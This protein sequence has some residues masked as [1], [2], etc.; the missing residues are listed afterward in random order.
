M[1]PK[2]ASK[3]HNLL[4]TRLRAVA[5][6]QGSA[7]SASPPVEPAALAPVAGLLFFSGFCALIFQVSW[8]REFRL[9]FGAST[10][11]SSAVLAVFMGGLGIGNA[12]LGRRADRAK[13]PLAFY[14]L[15]E[16]SI[17]MAAAASPRLIDALHG[18]YIFLGGQLA[19]GFP[20]ATAVRLAISAVV[21]G[22]PTFLMGGTLPA[23]VRAVTIR[24]D[25]HRRGAAVLTA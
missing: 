8:F 21:L 7:S 4:M 11:A 3:A 15:L 24:E 17:A 12:I 23:A 13:S 22:V 1:L 9:L 2:S 16:L 18:L 10:A 20:L 25:H 5:A 14:A 6:G 19:L